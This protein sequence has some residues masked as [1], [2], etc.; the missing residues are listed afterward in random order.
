MMTLDAM[1]DIPTYVMFTRVDDAAILLN[2]R[3]NKYFVLEEVGARLWEL[4]NSGNGLRPS[5]ETLLNE[6]EVEPARLEQDV[7]ELLSKLTENELVE[8]VA[9]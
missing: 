4:L 1:L 7:L 8:V 5:Y 9:G 2:T 3:T 6:Y